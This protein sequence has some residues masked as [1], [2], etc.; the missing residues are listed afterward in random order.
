MTPAPA[1]FSSDLI[2]FP[3]ALARSGHSKCQVTHR[4]SASAQ[5]ILESVAQG[6]FV[7][8]LMLSCQLSRSFSGL[9]ECRHCGVRVVVLA[10]VDC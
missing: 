1:S 6:F 3:L 7:F 10:Y 9:G 2:K 5:N 4:R 8:F